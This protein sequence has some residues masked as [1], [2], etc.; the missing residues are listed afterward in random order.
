MDGA[1]LEA[2]ELVAT[3]SLSGHASPHEVAQ[4]L[5]LL[6]PLLP[7][8][9][10]A[11]A[12]CVC[13]AWRA[14][15]AHPALWEELSFE[16]CAARVREETLASLCARA[17]A[18]L[19]TLRLDAEACCAI[20]GDGMVAALRNGG[21]TG[22]R[23][24]YMPAADLETVNTLTLESAQQLAAACPLLQHAACVVQCD[25]RDTPAALAA[26]AALPGP[27]GLKCSSDED[28]EADL[29]QLAECLRANAALVSLDLS[30]NCMGAEGATQLAEGLRAHT[31]LTSLN[32]YMN[33]IG[34]AGATQLAASLL[35]NTTLNSLNLGF[36]N[37]EAEGATRLVECLRASSSI[38]SLDLGLNDIGDAG[39]TQLAECL[40][41][42]VTLKRLNLY[43]CYLYD[44]GATKLAE[45]LRFNTTLTSLDLNNNG[46][47]D[48]GA[49]QLAQCLR[50]NT[51]L[52]SLELCDN[53][54][55]IAGATELVAS[56]RLNATLTS[57]N[58][59]TNDIK[60][61]PDL[62]A[63]NALWAACPP[64][65]KLICA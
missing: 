7:L 3:P 11:R 56:L 19:R 46:I 16:R 27:N 10:R 48:A 47:G 6:L 53:S 14:A 62:A 54:I 52:A 30:D 57:L 12:A 24:L 17:G 32:L 51:A 36:N 42:N 41:V 21:C 22:V 44:A 5:S 29:T 8:D 38:T 33:E 35:A 55:G 18:A 20:S 50:V 9:C 37:I 59:S 61:E 31:G 63:F 40:R 64:H 43:S 2:H 25:L 60:E 26:L 58:L 34:D 4:A 45:C 39:V 13:R 23:R 15:A 28:S 65:C 1:L 49:T